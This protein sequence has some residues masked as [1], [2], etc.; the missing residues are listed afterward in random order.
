MSK[1]RTPKQILADIKNAW[2]IKVARSGQPPIETFERFF[3]RASNLA[4]AQNIEIKK[5]AKKL[6]SGIQYTSYEQR[7]HKN[8]VD[9]LKEEG[10]YSRLYRMGGKTAFD[11][12]IYNKNKQ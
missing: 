7:V 11:A 8:V 10:M 5:S 4:T 2:S 12:S 1:K 9:I 6:L 3:E